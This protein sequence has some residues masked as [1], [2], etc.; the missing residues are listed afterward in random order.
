MLIA[1]A[2]ES[3]DTRFF[4]MA[5][6]VGQHKHWE[7]FNIEWR[8]A[9][10]EY[11]L[12]HFH[13]KDFAGRRGPFSG[14]PEERRQSLMQALLTCVM[15]QPL[16]AFGVC[17]RIDDYHRLSP[18]AQSGFV[19][20]YMMCFYELTFGVSLEA[21]NEP[22]LPLDFVYSR[23]D[24]FKRMMRRW[25]SW[26]KIERDYG[27]DLGILAFRDMRGAPGLQAADLLAYELRHYYHLKDTRPELGIRFPFRM[28]LEHQGWMNA[29]TLKYLPGWYLEAQAAGIQQQFM[30]VI[31]SDLDTWS[32]MYRQ[33]GP[34]TAQTIRDTRQM[35]LLEKYLPWKPDQGDLP[36]WAKS[37]LTSE[38]RLFGLRMPV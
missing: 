30:N 38:P 12:D 21:R 13:M 11:Q 17:M 29:H 1:M 34:E 35:Q 14:W 37:L 22:L 16:R 15:S 28:I 27:Q 3:A 5:A 2:D 18:A 33:L 24:D 36:D 20:P 25:W 9:L 31:F 23:Q 19:G 8:A 4:A 10:S 7:P 6:Y 32:D 26:A